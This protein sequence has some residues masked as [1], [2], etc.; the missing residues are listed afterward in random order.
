M[1]QVPI[2]GGMHLFVALLAARCF[3]AAIDVP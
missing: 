3:A 2:G 1:T